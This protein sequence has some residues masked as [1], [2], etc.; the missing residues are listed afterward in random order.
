M[1]NVYTV[2][3]YNARTAKAYPNL[4]IPENIPAVALLSITNITEALDDFDTV[5]V[6]HQPLSSNS[7]SPTPG[8]S[9]A[10]GNGGGKHG[11]GRLWA[12]VGVILGV[13]LVI[14]VLVIRWLVRR[15]RTIRR[16]A[17]A[18][19]S[20][21]VDKS[22][23]VESPGSIALT[24][25]AASR[26]TPMDD[27]PIELAMDENTLRSKIWTDR[28]KYSRY[29][30]ASFLTSSTSTRA[31]EFAEPNDFGEMQLPSPDE[32]GQ[33]R[34]PRNDPL[35]TSRRSRAARSRS[36][37]RSLVGPM[38]D[39]YSTPLSLDTTL[40]AIPMLDEITPEAL[41]TGRYASFARQAQ[42]QYP[43]IPHNTSLSHMRIPEDPLRST[44]ER[45][46]HPSRT[47][48]LQP[49]TDEVRQSDAFQFHPPHPLAPDRS[50]GPAEPHLPVPPDLT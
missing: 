40:S 6:Q 37:G 48:T 41:S 22:G 39:G 12:L 2:L 21:S 7:T 11:L 24:T 49:S 15:R 44:S 13:T 31:G 30:G 33:D 46:P 16:I 50:E 19:G 23:D 26:D 29:S 32:N 18:T 47:S 34:H 9:T 38:D 45:I 27:I 5:R 20:S 35:V 14:I 43:S 25:L 1:R 4:T 10:P 17:V 3:S 36:R 28:H 42:A 8:T